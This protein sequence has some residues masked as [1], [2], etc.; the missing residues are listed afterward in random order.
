MTNGA[1]MVEAHTI[2][3]PSA[4]R[5]RPAHGAAWLSYLIVAVLIGLRLASETTAN[6]AFVGLGVYALFGRGCAV[7]ALLLSWLFTM[8][9]PGIAPEASLASAGRYVA[10]LGAATSALLYG[11]VFA[12]NARI[13]RA[14]AS[15]AMVGAL[16]VVHSLMFSNVVDVSVLKAVSWCVA[17]TALLSLW[18]GM[19]RDEQR[20]VTREIYWGMIGLILISIPLLASETGYL[21]NGSGFQGVLNHP[22]VFGPTVALL[23]AWTS[24][25]MLEER[26]PGWTLIG[27][28]GACI[29]LVLASQARTAGV[30]MV[31]GVALSIII[32]PWLSGKTIST[33]FP[34]LRSPRVWVTVLTTIFAALLLAP[35]IAERVTTFL[36]KGTTAGSFM[37]AYDTSRGFFIDKMLENIYAQPLTGIG[38]GVASDYAQMSIDRS[39]FLGLPTG[40]PVEK[41]VAFLAIVEELGLIAAGV[42]LFWLWRL[43]RGA[44]KAG[45]AALTVFIT[46]LL[47]NLGEATLFS[48]GGMG[49]LWLVLI[50]WAFSQQTVHHSHD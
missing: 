25:R 13:N 27:I 37:E 38:F 22:Q 4:R 15:A 35:I 44:A 12:G 28:V 48:P 23:G 3:R 40:A 6:F 49:M 2:Y 9:N 31:G 11:N 24:T 26:Q 36:R 16:L 21:R 18:M 30:A 17:V 39:G 34:G 20:R 7:R 10:I 47:L 29:A 45:L 19:K 46:I 42:V 32:A 1:R 50:T 5:R 14:T 41:G 8:I 43:L 33:M